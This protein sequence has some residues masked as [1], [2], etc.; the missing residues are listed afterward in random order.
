MAEKD[1]TDDHGKANSSAVTHQES[2]TSENHVGS[3]LSVSHAPHGSNSHLVP[4]HHLSTFSHP[5]VHYIP[6]ISMPT[7]SLESNGQPTHSNN[8]PPT[9]PASPVTFVSEVIKGAYGELH[10]DANGQYT[11]VLNPNSPQYILLNQNKH[12]T[13]H[14]VLNLSDGSKIVVQIP[15]T[16]KQDTPTISGD[17]AGVVTEDHKVDS[18]GLLHANGKIDVIDP[19]QNESSM[20]P[21]VLAGK[22]GSL[23]ID[24]DGHWQYHVDN[25]LSNIQALTSATSLHESFVIHTQDGTPQTLDMTIGG[26]DDN[27]VVTGIDTGVVTE[28]V[29]TQ[30]QGQL[31]VNDSDLGENHFQAS[32]INGH[33]GTL[34]ITKDGAWTYALDNSNPA[35]QRLAQGSTA[36]DIITVH[37]ADGTPHQ[38]TITVNGTNDSA[39][40]AGTNSGAVTEE[41]QLQTTGTLTVTDTDAGEAHFSDTDI[42]GSLGTLHLKD[43]GDW[44]YDLDNSNPKV[45]ALAQ[46]KT[47]TDTITVH[48]ADGT[49]HQVTITVNGT[50]DSALIAG[51]T[52]GSVTEE[53]KLHA[54]GQLSISDLDSGQ[55]HFQSTDIKGAYGSLH[56]DTDGLWTYDLDNSTVQ[57]LGDGD[58]LSETLTVN[59]ADGTPHD[60]KVWVYGSNDAPVVSA[61]VVLTNGTEDTSIQLST[62]ELLANATDVDH[63]DLGQLSIANLVS[64]HG[65]V[66]DNKDGTFTFTPEK[67]YNGD[68]H[69]SYD[70]KDAHGGVTHTG[71]TTN[72]AAVNDNP[73]VTPLT[74]SVSEGADNHHTLNL[75]L[76][77]TDKEGDALTISH[78]EYAIDGQPQAGKIPAGITLDA[79]GHTLIVDA[80]DPAFNHLANGQSQQI[81]I[82]YQVEDGHGGSTQQTATLTIAGTD[83]KATL[84]SNVIQLTET[85]AL[86]SEFKSYRG[87]LQLIDPDSGDNTQFVFSGKYLGQGFEPGHLDVWPNGTYQFRLDAGTNRHADDLI[88]SLHAG[89]SKE[90]PYEVETSD[91]QKLTIMV[92]VTGEDNQAKIVVTPYSS[93][94]NHVYE[95]HTSFGNTTHQLS[96]GGTLHVIDPDHD[97]AGFIAQTITTTEGGRFNINAQGHWSY[98]IDNDKVQHLGAGESFQQTFTV[99]SIDGSAKKDITVT[100]HGTNDVPIVASVISGQTATEDGAFAFS[101]PAGTF[102]DIDAKD[103]LTLSAGSLPGWLSFDPTT[104]TFTGTPT[105]SDVGTTQ[106][107]VTATDAHGATVSTAFDL[108][109]N[110]TND[111]PTL[112]PIAS[113]SVD[114]DGQQATGQLSATDPDTGDSLTY[115]VAS[116]VAGLTLNADGSYSFDPSNAA[117]QSLPDGQTQTVTIPVTVTDSAGATDTQKLT[118]TMTGTNDV[119]RISGVDTGTATED[120]VSHG[121]NNLI[122]SGQLRVADV[123]SGEGMFTVTGQSNHQAGL[124]ERGTP[125]AGDHGLGQFVVHAN[126]TWT[127]IAD[128]TS[129]KIQALAEH[130]T[131]QE[132]FTVHSKDGTAHTITVDIVGTND[133]PTVSSS[134]TLAAGT[135]DTAVTLTEAQLLANA[136]DVDNGETAQLSVHN[137]S[138]DHGTITDNKDGTYTFTPNA[139]YNGPVHF[140]YDVQDPQGETVATSASMNLAAVDDAAVITGT[141]G[142]L[143]EEDN[144]YYGYTI[145]TSGQFQ[146][147][148]PD[149]PGQSKFPDGL[150]HHTGTLGGTLQL[151]GNG[152]Y[153][154]HIDNSTV[155]HLAKGQEAKETFTI[156]SVDGTPHQ[157]EFVIEGTNDAPVANIVT[158]SNGIEDTHYQMQASQFGFTDVDSGDT[159]HAITITDIPAVSQGKFVLDGQEVSAGQSISTAD[160]SKLQFV[161]TKDF[162][163]DVQFKYTVNDGRTDSVEATNTLHIANTDDASV[164]SGDRQA[165]VNEG[166]IGDTVTATGQLSITDV[167]TGDNP[168]FIDV[169]S[170]ATTYGHIEMR[171]GQWTYTLDESKVQHL[172]P[173]QPAVQD[174]YTFKASDGSTQIV[175]ITIQ[176]TNDKPIIESAHAAAVG[177]SSTLK[178]Q[179]VDVISN[180]TG[181]NIN[182]APSNAENMARWGTDQVGVGS[183]VKLVGLYKPGS[184]HNWI[185]NPA[186]TTTAHS[187]AGGF[188]RIDNHDWWHTNGVPDTVNTGSGGA[189]GHGNA[190]T[191]GIAVFEDNTGHQTIAIVNRVCTGGGSEVDYLYYHSYQHLQVGNTVYS[192]TATAGETINV[193]DGNHQIASVIADT[194]GHWEISASNLTDGKHTI[195]VENSA[196]EHSAETILQV[197]GHTVQNI[198]PAALNAEIKEDAAQTTI[199]GELRTSD[200]DT[201]DTASFTVQA[202]HATKYGHF[203]IDS[204][205]HYHFT[206]DNNNADVDHL[207]VHQT[208]TEVIPVT[209]TSTDGTSVT[210]NVT[211][212]IQGSLDKPILNATAPDAQQGTT[213][214]LNLNVATTDTGGD[215]EDLLIKI[216]GLPDAAT[217]NHGTH[218]AVAKMWVL[219][220]SDLNG[221][222]LNLHN[223]NFHGDL[224]FNATATASAGGESQSATQAISLF[225]NAPPSVTSGVTSSKAEDSGM[226]AIDL[227]SGA[228][229]AD[230]GDTLSVGHIEYQIGTASKTSTVPSFLTMSKGGH[231][232]IVNSNTPEFQHLAVGETE[233]VKITYNITDSHGGTVQQS[234]TLTVTGTNDSPVITGSTTAKTVTEDGASATIDLLSG[235]TDV[236]GDTLSIAGIETSIDGAAATS[237]LAAGLTL[238]ADGHTITIDPS[239]KAFQDI[240][241]GVTRNITVS[242]NVDDGHGGTVP[243]TAQVEVVG[244]N[245]RPT[246]TLFSQMAATDEDRAI[247]LTKAQILTGI[248]AKDVDGDSLSITDLNVSSHGTLVDNHDGT[249]TITPDANFHGHLMIV[250]K[251]SDGSES[252]PFANP[253]VVSSVNDATKVVA[254]SASTTEDTDIVLTKSQLLAGATDVDGD[255]LDIN[256]VTVNGGHGTVTDNHDG[257][258]TLHPEE[259]YKG[260]ITLGYK[261]NDGTADVDN[262]MTVAVTSVT[263]A[264]DINLSVAPQKGFQTDSAHHLS[265]DAILNPDGGGD[266]T[267]RDDGNSLTFEMGITLDKSE[268][269]HN[270][271]VIAQYGG[272][273]SSPGKLDYAQMHYYSDGS[274]IG[275]GGVT[276]TNPHSVTVWIS[277]MDPIETH[278]DITDGKLHRLTVVVDEG[279][280]NKAPTMSIF[281]NGKPVDYPDGSNSESMPTHYLGDSGS[282]EHY[283]T[284]PK[285]G[286]T[287]TEN[288]FFEASTISIPYGGG[289]ANVPTSLTERAG[290]TELVIGTGRSPISLGDGRY[291]TGYDHGHIVWS[292]GS[293]HDGGNVP[294]ITPI[295]A[296]IEHVTVVK[297]AVAASQVA[298]GPL[299]E[300]GLDP[301]HV[302]IDLGVNGAGIVDHTGLHST[303]VPS[304]S[305]HSHVINTAGINVTNDPHHLVINADVTPHDKD[306]ALQAVHLHGLP[307]GSVVTDGAHTHTIDATDQKDGLDILGWTRSSIEVRIP[308]GVNHNAIITVE[309]TTQN[310]DGTHAHSASSAP[311]ILDPAHAG[312]VIVSAPPISG[313]EDKGPY[314]LTLTAIDPT[315]AHAAVTFA[316]S[317]LPAG[318]TLSAGSYDANTKTWT[319]TPSEANGLQITLPKDFSGSVTPHITATS[320]AGHS[321]S[322]DMSGS[323]TDTQDVAVISGTDSASITEDIH[324]QSSGIIETNQNQLNVRDPDAGEALFTPTGTPSGSGS[325]ATGSWVAGDKGIGQ[326]ILHAD[327]RWLYKVDNDNTHIKSLGDGDTF[328]ETLTVQTKDGTTHQLT[329]TIHGTNDQPVIDA[330]SAVTAIEGGHTAHKGQITTTDVDTGDSATYTVITPTTGQHVPGFTLNADGSY[331]FDA[332]DAGYD[333]LALGKTEQVSVSV[334]VTDG[335]GA[336][337]QKDL[338]ITITGTNDRP[339]VGSSLAQHIHSIDEDTTQHFSAKD[340]G[341]IDKDHGDQ[342]DHIT[343]TALPDAFKGQFEYDGH[344]ITIPLDVL[345]ADISKL[346][347]VP[348]QDYNGGVQFGFTVND[349]HTD[350]FPK[351]G[352][353]EI[354]PVDDISTVSGTDT[355]SMTEGSAANTHADLTVAKGAWLANVDGHFDFPEVVANDPNAGRWYAIVGAGVAGGAA[356]GMKIET[357][358]WVMNMGDPN[359]GHNGYMTFTRNTNSATASYNAVDRVEGDLLINDPDTVPATFIDVTDSLGDNGYGNFSMHNGHWSFVGGDKTTALADG[360]KATETFTFN[361]S[362]GVTHQVTVNLTGSDTKAEFKGDISANLKEGDIG[363]TVSAHGTLNIVDVD[364]GQNPIIADFHDKNGVNGYGHFSMVNNQWTYEI[365]QTKVQKLNASE[366]VQDKITVTASDGTTQDIVISIRGTNDAPEVTGAVANTDDSEGHAI[367]MTLPSNLFTDVEGDSFT[368]SLAVSQHTE[369]AVNPDSVN[370]GWQGKDTALGMPTWLHFDEKTGRIW[371]TPPH[372]ADGDLDITVTATDANGAKGTY[373]FHIAVT[374][375]DA[376]GIAHANVNEDDRATGQHSANGQLDAYHNGQHIIWHE[377]ATGQDSTPNMIQGKYGHLQIST[378]GTWIYFLDHDGDQHWANKDLNALKAGQVE[379]EH[380]TIHGL[381]NGK[382]VATEQVIIAVTGKNDGATINGTMTSK[383]VS[384]IT[385]DAAKDTLTG[386]LNLVDADHGEDQFIPD[387]HIAGT[388][389]HLELAANGDWV[390]HLD[391]SLAT[392]NSLSAAQGGTE[393]FT[394]NSPDNTASHTIT[395]NVNGVDD[396][397]TSPAP[398]PPVQ[399][400]EPDF[401]AETSEDISVTLDDVGLVVPDSQHQAVNAHPVTGAAAYLDA[402]GIS[403]PPP[404][405]NDTIEHQLPADIDIVMAE[406]DHAALGH[407][408]VSHIDLSDALEHQG[409]EHEHDTNQQD[410]DDTQHHNQVDDL[411]DIDPNS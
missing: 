102:D 65:I 263:D 266:H 57:A 356:H 306:D 220:K 142:H 86:D 275:N 259:N 398:P 334:T 172:D 252:R 27:A 358:Q 241:A 180:P 242:F 84:V 212:T 188:S 68:V 249:Y 163:G 11:F 211:I 284:A 100:V 128:N 82:T 32:Q 164:I 125:V 404:S 159:L 370:P 280:G 33:L 298:Q 247:T 2:P 401:S 24:A 281:D 365:D 169:A 337:D 350:S 346:T 13:D 331:E 69:F 355:L 202:D 197:S 145:K 192:G 405:A 72:L 262:H 403:P 161:P 71:A 269:Y 273:I 14:F 324:V 191:G 46:G 304:G 386:H 240:A 260:D 165:V 289:H 234:A 44:S 396:P 132:T 364:T 276:L 94:N 187:G 222:E 250:G 154:Y 391:N 75:L 406:A 183:G 366:S 361:T 115:S 60:I 134:V 126:G 268:T 210:T 98:N 80:T 28:D 301:K 381:Q 78:L 114:E 258:W 95:D 359:Y 311:V 390:Y 106:V 408:D 91:G 176:G 55:D 342:L 218:D 326:F 221:L 255:T 146:V 302:L 313:V 251:V 5:Q 320:S 288:G 387:P 6:S 47:A 74:D 108:V 64:N 341:F 193:M 87:L 287:I 338:I 156:H 25:S 105:N 360:E 237:G 349:G 119:A 299:G 116:P 329:S 243:R 308:A 141:G 138:A 233:T 314:D 37:S 344:P 277:G 278:I 392:T 177:T 104:G 133:A 267:A 139:D 103:S 223:A 333:H 40:I 45:Q 394:I 353:F 254:T 200:V 196:G 62:A 110:N 151:Y 81:A 41:T 181:A 245:D 9:T 379:Q 203:S 216:S 117:Y 143:L 367:D 335:A 107:T 49:P 54:S 219:H 399:H 256:S 286:F 206:I 319:I 39:V 21:E 23:S 238:G 384:T 20:K 340:F 208:L 67:D 83:D 225:V 79:D 59:A 160:I 4:S 162:N 195:H 99:E 411:P 312:D 186:T 121:S 185:T 257:T 52:S 354:I 97:Q 16:G 332:T 230:T 111:A 77:A 402:L 283:L 204:N 179:D 92:K 155:N 322:I 309:A 124:H 270:G 178:L 261:V 175:D 295:V 232:L 35:V 305:D 7:I 12:G 29:T 410:H 10:V 236:D 357:T 213:I 380:F 246:V 122:V 296:T 166:D 303:V 73:D 56:I 127:F 317:G 363:D 339:T 144:L 113:V 18:H 109:V 170:T 348:A 373:D 158:L 70:V 376:K 347:F 378:G 214:A 182:V 227:L 149:G 61:E 253:L 323:I 22:Y 112:N 316:V 171:N 15:V 90:F 51:T 375:V 8:T 148:D 395:I 147:V 120:S 150:H 244:T 264:A 205:G 215:T 137:L 239:N 101:V 136:S 140:T 292:H 352:N 53:S 226:G 274:R 85:Q 369:E 130:Q 131:I 118:I 38:I 325:T 372:S 407:D 345:T 371:G 209:S 36:T 189:T 343:I 43:N 152:N 58:K 89:E 351:I 224:H 336:T 383:S 198:T 374:D 167:D 26:N 310:P 88:G 300:Q 294:P 31:T 235:A 368:L 297:E 385:E 328:T 194:N 135:E 217:L 400:D 42:I 362:D 315:D 1:V 207:G 199:N 229:D 168:S 201:G 93:L 48:S 228:T 66:I 285:A 30:I 184:D 282:S 293:N 157:V 265:I 50:N 330:T 389:G 291:A 3:T 231:I 307:V 318:A 63:N 153:F 129:L 271:D 174:H 190:W 272:H 17:L 409:H 123:D 382:E 96:S 19:D 34:T 393:T 279:Q 397:L 388:Y 321:H 248:G 290:S 377:Q 76:G 327:G 173:D